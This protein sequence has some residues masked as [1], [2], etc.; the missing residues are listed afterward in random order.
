MFAFPHWI[1]CS[2]KTGLCAMHFFCIKLD[3]VKWQ[4]EVWFW[5]MAALVKIERRHD[6]LPFLR[7]FL[8]N[9]GYG[10][11]WYNHKRDCMEI[12]DSREYLI[13]IG[14]LNLYSLRRSV[15]LNLFLAS[16]KLVQHIVKSKYKQ[17]AE[18]FEETQ[19]KLCA[20][21]FHLWPKSSSPWSFVSV[22]NIYETMF[23]L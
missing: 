1:Y 21:F 16:E 22:K 19:K 7:M 11:V 15:V 5:H 3:Q 9:L 8:Q 20:E 2:V 14:N 23:F 4:H 10:I 13:C 12:H 18:H 6:F 17:L